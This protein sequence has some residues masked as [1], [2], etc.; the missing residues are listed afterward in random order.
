MS[1]A[2]PSVASNGMLETSSRTFRCAS[3]TDAN[4]ETLEYRIVGINHDDLVDGSGKVGLTFLTTSRGIYSRENAMDTSIGG[5]EKSELR[6]KMNSGEIWNLVPSDFQTKVKTVEKLTINVG[7]TDKN[8]AVTA[9][10]DRLFL[11]SYS[12][13]VPTSHCASDCPWTSSKGTQYEAFEGKVTKNNSGNAC[14]Q[15]GGHWWERSVNP[16][17]SECFL[18]VY[19][20][21]GLSYDSFAASLSCVCPA[22]CI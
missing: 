12:E 13:I 3:R 17:N 7:G 5:W 11:L 15:I 8:A 16:R 9:I 4:G 10:T 19:S 22:W 18:Y 21:G 2:L 14:L 6:E 20:N 1:P